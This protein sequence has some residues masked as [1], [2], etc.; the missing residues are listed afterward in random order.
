VLAEE[1]P[2]QERT[3]EGKAGPPQE[4]MG[5]PP[6]VYKAEDGTAEREEKIEIRQFGP[7]Y[8]C[9]GRRRPITLP[10]ARLGQ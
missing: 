1:P 9:D 7:Y 3:E 10:E 8:Q 4:R 6:V 2:Q 5:H